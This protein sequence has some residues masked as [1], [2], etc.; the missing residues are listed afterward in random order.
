MW[1]NL[2]RC[3]VHEWIFG[4]LIKNP[5]ALKKRHEILL[6]QGISSSFPTVLSYLTSKR[7]FIMH[8]VYIL[9]ETRRCSVRNLICFMLWVAWLLL[10]VFW[11]DGDEDW[12]LFHWFYL[13]LFFMIFRVGLVGRIYMIEFFVICVW[14]LF[15][16]KLVQAKSLE[17]YLGTY[18]WKTSVFKRML[19]IDT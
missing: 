1:I 5:L 15:S 8:C 11:S 12:I 7:G 16:L 4:C 18:F 17:W 14:F 13:I 6:L 3:L 19:R 2:H 9:N 10:N